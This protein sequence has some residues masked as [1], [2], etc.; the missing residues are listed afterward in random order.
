MRR[1][2]RLPEV[3]AHHIHQCM[4]G[5]QGAQ[6]HHAAGC[7]PFIH[8][9][10]ACCQ[11]GPRRCTHSKPHR[12]FWGVGHDGL[13]RTAHLKTYP[14]P[15]CWFL[16]TSLLEETRSRFPELCVGPIGPPIQSL[17]VV[18]PPRAWTLNDERAL[19]AMVD[20][21]D[22]SDGWCVPTGLRRFVAPWD[23]YLVQ[24]ISMDCMLHRT[25]VDPAV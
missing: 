19:R 8:G 1:L 12:G 11:A 7:S 20:L 18:R 3:Q 23:P 5:G 10:L 2:Q 14:S 13:W 6:A 24:G 9:R 21:D 16:A 25:S 4:F 17:A 22:A 15:L